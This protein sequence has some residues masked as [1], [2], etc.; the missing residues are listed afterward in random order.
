MNEMTILRDGSVTLD[1]VSKH[2][3]SGAA[4]ITALD[5]LTLRIDSG[6]AVAVTGASGSGKSTL[7]HIVG[8]FEKPSAGRI[9][10][11]TR[12][13]T[14]LRGE[15]LV[16][17]RRAVGFVFQRFNLLPALSA[18]DNVMM[19]LL[20]TRMK[21]KERRHR[22]MEALRQVGLEERTEALPSRLSG[23]QQQRVAIAR[24]VVGEPELILADEPTGN[25]DAINGIKILDL[26]LTLCKDRGTTLVVVTHDQNVASS[27][28][29]IVHLVD[30]RV[31]EPRSTDEVQSGG[32]PNI[33]S[34]L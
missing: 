1:V 11:G 6:A 31:A 23:G 12:E 7:L 17:H 33:E 29:R 30:G 32:T 3:G 18:I 24:A 26:L 4:R 8:G 25:L 16:R 28:E 10:V 15:E 5:A 27:C 34:A 14:S 2:Y 21:S 20:C 9:K 22:A 13:I 19:P